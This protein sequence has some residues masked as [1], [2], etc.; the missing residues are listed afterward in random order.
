[1]S[2]SELPGSHARR[3]LADLSTPQAAFDRAVATHSQDFGQFFLAKL[4]G[5]E[6]SYEGD[7]CVVGFVAEEYLQNPRGTLQ[8]GV[9]AT[10]LDLAMGHAVRH[11]GL[12]A[13]TIA[14]DVRYLRAVKSGPIRVV[15]RPAHRGRTI[16]TMRG[17]AHAGA[18]LIATALASFAVE[19]R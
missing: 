16:W 1:M 13:A 12:G 4:L 11:A 8:G 10:A 14:L 3:T 19:S 5:F 15:A 18:D 17:E 9:I 7:A 6:V 2:D